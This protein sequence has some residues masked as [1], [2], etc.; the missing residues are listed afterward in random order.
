MSH[1]FLT[2]YFFSLPASEKEELIKKQFFGENLWIVYLDDD[3][4]AIEVFKDQVTGLG[5]K[6]FAHTDSEIVKK[7]IQKNKSKIL[8]IFSDFKMPALN[9]FEFR[10]VTRELSGE[11]PFCILSSFVDKEMN[12]KGMELKIEL[13]YQK[14]FN[15]QTFIEFL[16]HQ[17]ETRLSAMR[18]EIEM[19]HGF[20]E[21]ASNLLEQIEECCLDLESNPN[22]SDLIA[23]VF[24]MVHTI[25]GSSGFFEPR[26]L[27]EFAHAF[28]DLLKLVQNG[29]K[30][31]TP[32]MISVWLKGLDYLKIFV[33]EFKT[34]Q[35]KDYKIHEI[36]KIFDVIPEANDGSQ[37]DSQ[38]NDESLKVE[39]KETKSSDIKVAT[40]LLDEFMQISGEMTVIRNMLN[41]TVR[42]I[43]KQYR[44]DKDVGMLSELLEE[45]HKINSD[46]QNKITDIRRVSAN[47]LVK[48]ITR[49]VRDTA[50]AL[51]KEVDFIVE[52]EDLRLDNSI[53]EV[54][55]KSL[56]HMMRNS[57]DHG[58]ES[59]DERKKL[60]KDP[61]GKLILSFK[62]VAE[63]VRVTISDDGK[64]INTEKIREKVISQK[65]RTSEDAARLSDPELWAMIFESGFSTAQVTTEFSGRGVGMSMVKDSVESMKGRIEIQSVKGKGASF[66][67]VIPV[68]KSVLITNCLFVRSE[69][70]QFGIPQEYI[71]RV[72]D[73]RIMNKNKIQSS[74][75]GHFLIEEDELV[76]IISLSSILGK[77][78][79]E[80]EPFLVLLKY[81]QQLFALKVDQVFDIEDTVIKALN[82]QTLKNLGLYLGGTFLGDATVGLI[83]D[84]PSMA[85][86]MGLTGM[87]KHIDHKV[88]K[89]TTENLI[90]KQYLVF[91]STCKGKLALED[92]HV[93]R[94]EKFKLDQIQYSAG[95]PV[96]PYREGILSLIH[97]GKI[98]SSEVKDSNCSE[99]TTIILRREGEQ[100]IGLVIDQVCDLISTYEKIEKSMRP[101]TGIAG[102]FQ[103]GKEIL[104]VIE[105]KDLL[106]EATSAHR[107]TAAYAQ[108]A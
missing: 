101:M 49:I 93:T 31:V 77:E 102:S 78:R 13:F 66:T 40:Y 92:I 25:K 19:L 103:H 99:L 45:M 82:V 104:S 2:D 42:S 69:N 26:D 91:E 1:Q 95:L 75:G 55:S 97:L 7:F 30:K 37:V 57:L 72:M 41:K 67:L 22:N 3:E 14:T 11:I 60:G 98:L 34:G 106:K 23:K 47:H 17:G 44:G 94:V 76:P 79:N 15:T 96:I 48:P 65:L 51:G 88:E 35:H 8:V 50:R 63:V 29:Q 43:E 89:S 12:S 24:G 9:G 27:H 70:K 80:K 58:L 36:K 10:K 83:F 71:Y 86:K 32:G 53:A 18:D 81:Q 61:K 38:V 6:V 16:K 21:D 100:A 108:V 105:L 33:D 52:G 87:K 54:L 56:V 39:T 85:E 4:L 73:E 107:E 62:N 64:G 90:Q 68:P 59:T 28:E 84:I 20:T 46:V 5:F 74:Q